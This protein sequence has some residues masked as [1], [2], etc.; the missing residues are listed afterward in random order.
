MDF[1]D[2]YKSVFDLTPG[3]YNDKYYGNSKGQLIKRK[4]MIKMNEYL[5]SKNIRT[6]NEF[7]QFL[8]NEKIDNFHKLTLFIDYHLNLNSK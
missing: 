3:I 1:K 7:K 4:N 5:I 2:V 6:D 8:I